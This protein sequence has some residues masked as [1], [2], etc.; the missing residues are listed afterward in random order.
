VAADVYTA[1]I[2]ELAS[3]YVS[4]NVRLW[5]RYAEGLRRVS[6]G[7][8]PRA[9]TAATP[10]ASLGNVPIFA[11]QLMQLNLTHYSELLNTYADF[12]NRMISTVLQPQ[13]TAAAAAPPPT[14]PAASAGSSARLELIFDGATGET[15]SQSFAVAN[16][17][18]EPIDV[19][20]EL[21]EFVAEEG[22]AQFRAPVTFVPDRFVLSPGAER[23]VECRIPIAAAF[24]PGTRY[25]ALV[26]V[27]G[28]PAL[29]TALVVVPR[30]GVGERRVHEGEVVESAPTVEASVVTAEVV[31]TSGR[32]EA[33][34]PRPRART[35]GRRKR[36]G[37][38]TPSRNS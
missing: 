32:R 10:S 18:T 11:Q 23:V 20:F 8:M 16:K 36:A 25:M 34:Q 1:K 9:E 5:Q 29:D 35:A 26:R 6:E 14:P 22:A 30:H 33:K 4:D 7:V 21:T 27:T 38:K 28:F 17:K 3:R 24:V 19:A 12:T 2:S 37:R 13:E 31:A 15:V